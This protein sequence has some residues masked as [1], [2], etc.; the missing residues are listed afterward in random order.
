MNDWVDGL[1]LATALG[2]GLMAGVWFAFSAFVMQALER[3][4]T[5]QGVAAMQS[6]N[7][8]AVLPP[9]MIALFGVALACLGLIG[10]S[11]L[12]WSD[13]R[14]I[15]VLAAAVVYLIGTVGVTIAG[16]VPLNDALAP[17]APHSEAAAREW[18][19]FLDSWTVWNHV[20][21]VTSL[22]AAGLLTAGL[23]QD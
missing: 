10:W 1:T 16:N 13:A 17:L 11:A 23:L 19:H 18:A 22:V 6:I 5:A 4:P 15:W 2:C 14:A 20:R 9:L 21:T 8:T 12:N 7:R 3:L